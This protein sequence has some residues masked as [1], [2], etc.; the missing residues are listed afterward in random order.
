[1]VTRYLPRKPAP[2][3]PAALPVA[4]A[5]AA[6]AGLA[7]LTQM[8]RDAQGRLLTV[9]ALV[10]V[11]LRPSLMAGAVDEAGWTL[12]VT[13]ASAAAKLRQLR[14][15]LES[16]LLQRHGPGELRIKFAIR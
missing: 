5:L 11:A 14:P 4:R 2:A 8:A 13:S 3:V 15:F 10:P 12:L 1:M 7:Q 16:A 9:Q 6:H